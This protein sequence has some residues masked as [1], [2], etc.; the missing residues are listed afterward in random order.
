MLS[1]SIQY[2]IALLSIT[3]H[4]VVLKCMKKFGR[5]EKIAKKNIVL[6][7]VHSYI[8]HI[9]ILIHYTPYVCLC[10]LATVQR[11]RSRT[12][13]VRQHPS[14]VRN[15]ENPSS[16]HTLAALLV[17]VCRIRY[18]CPVHHL[19]RCSQHCMPL[20]LQ[21]TQID[22]LKIFYKYKRCHVI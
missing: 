14:A 1:N 8:I 10:V 18:V 3:K 19:L 20:H 9:L 22:K 15:C 11:K 13:T 16:L 4:T 7:T 5:S 2:L 12:A 17:S 21:L 6:K